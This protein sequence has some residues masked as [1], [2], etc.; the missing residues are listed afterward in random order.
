MDAYNWANY[1]PSEYMGAPINLQLVG[2]K[3]NCEKVIRAV[4]LIQ[5]CLGVE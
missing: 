4:D 3:W 1:E 5:A 2:K